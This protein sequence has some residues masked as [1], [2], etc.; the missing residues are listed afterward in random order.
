MPTIH[1][2]SCG[3]CELA[4]RF[5]MLFWPGSMLKG[6]TL[7]CSRSAPGSGALLIGVS[8]AMFSVLGDADLPVEPDGFGVADRGDAELP[9]AAPTTRIAT[10]RPTCRRRKFT[11]RR[12]TH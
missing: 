2:S 11:V 6:P 8:D 7:K 3:C 4:P 9:Q 1:P 10:T 12:L 5:A